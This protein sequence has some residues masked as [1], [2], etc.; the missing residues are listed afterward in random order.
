[1]VISAAISGSSRLSAVCIA[2]TP[3]TK[4]EINATIPRDPIIKSSISLKIK[5]GEHVHITGENGSGK[6]SLIKIIAGIY[7]P[8]QG[9]VYFNNLNFSSLNINEL[10]SE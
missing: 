5:S 10:R 3:P 2:T 7:E 9:N 1:M 6:S 8:S 4:N